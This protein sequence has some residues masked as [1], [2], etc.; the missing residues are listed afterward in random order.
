MKIAYII[1]AHKGNEQL[2]LLLDCLADDETDIY[3]HIDLKNEN[4]YKDIKSYTK[5]NKNI[6][7]LSNRINVNW[8]GFSQVEATLNCMK[9]IKNSGKKYDYISYIS[10]QDFPIKNNSHIKNFL[11]KNKSK[12]F[13]EYSVLED[14][15][16]FR[17]KQYNLFRESKNIRK[18]YMRIIDNI[19]RRFQKLIINRKNFK[20]IDLYHGS[21][22]FTITMGCMEYILEYIHNNPKYISDFKYTLCPDEHF[23]QM[24]VLNSKF[25]DNV[26]N[27]NLRYIDWKRPANS[28]RTL[29]ISDLEKLKKS[30]KLIARKFDID[31]SRDLVEAIKQII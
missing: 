27:N 28:P 31:Y 18:L 12:E 21:S 20:N 3:V 22:W 15:D 23:F 13:I 6:F 4:L 19:M 11:E 17:L 7:I 25:K 10:G 16:M 30:D 9:I 8:S 1:A 5:N 2:K 26:V 14:I 24:I 29:D